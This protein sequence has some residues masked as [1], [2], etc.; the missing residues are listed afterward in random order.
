MIKT[1]NSKVNIELLAENQRLRENLTSANIEI[2]YLEQKL[3]VAGR[4]N[5]HIM[6]YVRH[7]EGKG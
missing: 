5:E 6:E 3:L 4:S 2:K 7:L 1:D